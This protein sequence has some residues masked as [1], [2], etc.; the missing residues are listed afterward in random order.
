MTRRGTAKLGSL[1]DDFQ[2]LDGRLDRPVSETEHKVPD[3]VQLEGDRLL[4]KFKRHTA[5]E[6][7]ILRGG[8]S[9][10]RGTT[11]H[12][13]EGMLLGFCRLS[14]ASP[15]IILG[16]ARKWGVLR[17]CEHGLPCTHQAPL[18]LDLGDRA[19][20]LHSSCQALEDRNFG[21][22]WEPLDSWRKLS[23]RA[24]FILILAQDIH[25]KSG[26]PS[27]KRR[28]TLAN[29]VNA[30]LEIGGV[31]LSLDWDTQEPR[32]DLSGSGL[33]GSLAMQILLTVSRT[34]GLG[35]CSACGEPYM[36]K[37]Q[38]N[39]NR[40]SYCPIC[41]R[42]KIPRRDAARDYRRRTLG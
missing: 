3:I 25:Q 35:F 37:N 11:R 19:K 36:P 13:G 7:D 6:G 32:I 9:T 42:K 38:P 22:W 1:K 24:R 16:Y 10:F 18:F 14:E 15:E 28:I 5:I 27:M 30:W 23:R 17:I 2:R 40:R 39:P 29:Q 31:S 34:D 26:N 8:K 20:L 21:G 12:A 41:R 4:W 33:F